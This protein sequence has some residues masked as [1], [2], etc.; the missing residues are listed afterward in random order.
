MIFLAFASW[1]H[2]GCH[3]S[4]HYILTL[5]LEARSRG[6]CESRQFLFKH[7][8]FTRSEKAFPSRVP[9]VILVSVEWYPGVKGPSPGIWTKLG[10]FFAGKKCGVGNYSDCHMPHIPTYLPEWRPQNFK[11]WLQL[12]S[13]ALKDVFSLLGSFFWI[14]T[15]SSGTI[16]GH[17]SPAAL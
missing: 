1:S 4:K 9:Y 12:G 14:F 11:F 7:L 5:C 13:A 17:L 10:G 8:F 2:N 6:K 3:S 16:T 15:F